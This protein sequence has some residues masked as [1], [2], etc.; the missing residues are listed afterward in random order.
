MVVNLL[1]R[2]LPRIT[3]M[4]QNNTEI[5]AAPLSQ[6]EERKVD[7]SDFRKVVCKNLVNC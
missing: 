2:N 7:E 4:E 5:E 6:N 1:L 3:Q